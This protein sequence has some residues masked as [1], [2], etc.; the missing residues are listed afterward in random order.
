MDLKT[1]LFSLLIK[2]EPHDS[3]ADAAG[4][5]SESTEKIYTCLI[6]GTQFLSRKKCKKYIKLLILELW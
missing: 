4:Y 1:N 2:E 3:R 6:D 5:Y